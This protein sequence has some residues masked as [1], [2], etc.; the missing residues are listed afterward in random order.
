MDLPSPLALLRGRIYMPWAVIP[1][2]ELVELPGRGTTYVTDTP[3]PTQHAPV[4]VLLHALGCTGLL[5]WYP[6]I[7]RLS[8]RFRVL[9]LDQ[10]WH[11]QGIRTE[12]FSLADCADDVATLLDV[13][14]ID[15]AVIAGYSM[16]SIVAQ[17]VWRQHRDRTSGLVLC[18]TTD[19]FQGSAPERMFFSTM[20]FAMSGTRSMSRSRTDSHATRAAGVSV[21]LG[22]EDVDAWAIHE[23]RRTSAW[24]IAQAT[25]A[26]GRHH[27][28]PWLRQIDVPTA[29]VTL[30]NDKI[31]PHERQ[32]RLARS[33]PGATIHDI[34]AGHAACVLESERFVPAVVEAAGTVMARVRD[35]RR[36]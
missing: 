5:T 29:V 7:A 14:G 25:A 3:G 10:R 19:R 9:T 36:R 32:V 23:F 6:S 30:R 26:L 18:A 15:Q 21:G 11:G 2:G 33:I 17:R 1:P 4:I 13:Y 8:E 28:A 35:F 12:D 34:E 31:I 16:G 27:S 22:P 20:G 24:A